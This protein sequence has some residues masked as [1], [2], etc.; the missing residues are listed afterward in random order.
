[1]DKNF[2]KMNIMATTTNFNE[3]F[4]AIELSDYE[5]VDSMYR[6]V[7]ECTDYGLYKTQTAKGVDNGWILSCEGVDFSLHILTQKAKEEF[8]R[9]I[10]ERYCNNEPEDAWYSV[11]REM[12][13]KD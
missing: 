4:D 7:S 5:E 9:E 11:Q 6:S 1:M 10:E 2:I 12:R 3:W 8:L 13:K